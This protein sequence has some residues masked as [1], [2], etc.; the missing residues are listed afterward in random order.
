MSYDG[1]WYGIISSN[2]PSHIIFNEE[3]V[4]ENRSR[5]SHTSVYLIDG[6]TSG[7]YFEKT[8]WKGERESLHCECA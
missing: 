5:E 4:A 7:I 8:R 6:I 2:R 3:N 1:R